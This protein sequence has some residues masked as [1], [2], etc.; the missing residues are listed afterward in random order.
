[1]LLHD[2]YICTQ[3]NASCYVELNVSHFFSVDQHLHLLLGGPRLPFSPPPT[4]THSYVT[5]QVVQILF[6]AEGGCKRGVREHT[7]LFGLIYHILHFCTNFILQPLLQNHF[8]I[9]PIIQYLNNFNSNSFTFII[10][11]P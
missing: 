7:A 5:A 4:T 11:F 9:L 3:H 6:G 8:L 10:R 1:M 2:F